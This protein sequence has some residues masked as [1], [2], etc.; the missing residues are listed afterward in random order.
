M[1]YTKGSHLVCISDL[2]TSSL[3]VNRRKCALLIG[4]NQYIQSQL[5]YCV[6]DATDLQTTLERI[7]FNV[8]I[9]TNCNLKQFKGLIDRFA[10]TIQHDD[11]VLFYFGGHGKQIDDINYLLP[12]DY[13]YRGSEHEYIAEHAI[14]VRYVM[15]KF[16]EESG[17]ATIYLLDCCRDMI[18]PRSGSR[19][20]GLAPMLAPLQTMIVYACAPGKESLDQSRNG[21]NGIFMETL[22]EHIGRSD[23]EVEEMMKIVARAVYSQTGG[24]QLPYRTTSLVDNIY[25][26]VNDYQGEY[27]FLFVRLIFW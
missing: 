5:A 10:T 12:S 13:D 9:G 7:N 3:L 8:E 14:D 19:N 4:I 23:K 21:R 24:F 22:L 18:H 17:Y 16:N 27:A 26:V 6:N 11:L 25:L 2:M 15:K 1:V 20:I